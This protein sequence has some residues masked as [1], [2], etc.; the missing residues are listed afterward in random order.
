MSMTAEL[1]R[2]AESARWDAVTRRDA[3]ADDTFFYSVATTGV[4]CRPSCAA[5]LPN[6]RNVAFHESA[7]RRPPA[8]ASA[9]ASAAARTS[10]ATPSCTR[11]RVAAA[12]RR[13]EQALDAG[14]PPPDLAS[15]AA[16]ARLSPSHFHR[17]FKSAA[18]V[19]PRAYAAS[20]RAGRMKSALA[21]AP[22]VTEAIFEAGYGSSGRFYAASSGVL[23]MRP[24]IWRDG[25]RGEAI[26]FALGQCSL[27]AILVAATE[28][29]ICAIDLGDDAET[30]LAGLQRR[31]PR[32]KLTGG[33]ASFDALVARAVGLVE[34]P[35]RTE[36]L[37]LDVRG[38]AFQHR[39]WQALRDIPAGRTTSY[40]ELAARLG[41]PNGARAVAAAC[42]AN[43]AAV[44]I[45]CHRVVR[46]GGA[47]AG[48]RWGLARKQALL[49]REAR[50]A[51]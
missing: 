29:G 31:F 44:A 17:A 22:S 10:R 30:L 9:R 11:P 25:G 21:A 39:V 1:P 26:R 12:C 13:I 14:E 2:T 33:D 51:P 19:T 41:M 3:V 50:A 42:A 15:L 37:P 7:R 20:V 18:G 32:A 45:P 36:S 47:L 4:Y 28:A 40:T 5:R 16:G 46:I 35:G 24:R 48:Y 27:G 43:Q 6:R 23:G 34:R 8:P 49:E 38:T